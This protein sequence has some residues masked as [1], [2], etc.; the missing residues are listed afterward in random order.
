[1]ATPPNTTT[2]LA[3]LVTTGVA[4]ALPARLSVWTIIASPQP[5]TESA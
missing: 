5:I 1:M 4:V 3:R 2:V